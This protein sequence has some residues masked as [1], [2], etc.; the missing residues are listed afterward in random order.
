[1]EILY[2][3][4]PGNYGI[5]SEQ[6]VLIIIFKKVEQT[7]LHGYLHWIFLSENVCF[8]QFVWWLHELYVISTV[9]TCFNPEWFSEKYSHWPMLRVLGAD[10]M[11]KM[12][13]LLYCTKN[14]MVT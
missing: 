7:F 1:M 5:I 11:R 13:S 14:Q 4:S 2:I 3:S 9:S 6:T 10:Y 8:K 12:G